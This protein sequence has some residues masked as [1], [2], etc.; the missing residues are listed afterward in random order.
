MFGNYSYSYKMTHVSFQTFIHSRINSLQQ[1]MG[2][3]CATFNNHDIIR[4]GCKAAVRL[5][6]P[7]PNMITPN[8]VL[9]IIINMEMSNHNKN[10]NCQLV[11]RSSFE[12]SHSGQEKC[13][14]GSKEAPNDRGISRRCWFCALA[15][16]ENNLIGAVGVG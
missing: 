7:H 6:V 12:K 9:Q 8:K 3:Q 4:N 14:L 13:V 10:R 5:G 11:D 16:P 15:N 2:N 1:S